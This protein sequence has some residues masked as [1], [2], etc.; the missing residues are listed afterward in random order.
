MLA[1]TVMVIAGLTLALVGAAQII[2]VIGR[3]CQ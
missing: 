2:S 1:G 3:M